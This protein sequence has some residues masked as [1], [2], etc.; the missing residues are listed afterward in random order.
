MWRGNSFSLIISYKLG[1]ALY[2]GIVVQWNGVALRAGIFRILFNHGF[3]RISESG[4]RTNIIFFSYTILNSMLRENFEQV[5]E[6]R[7]D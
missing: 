6:I 2:S 5:R 7:N 3:S 1:T 4:A